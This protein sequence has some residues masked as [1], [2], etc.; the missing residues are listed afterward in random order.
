M[1]RTLPVGWVRIVSTDPPIT[2][3]ARL[4]PD[5]PDVTAG[6]GGWT[7]VTRPRRRPL[8]I[9]AGSPGLRMTLSILLDQWKA[10][11][12]VERQIAQLERL[13]TPTAAD[14]QPPRIRITSR[15][16]GVPHQRT[17]WVIDTITWGDAL[18]NRRGDRARQQATLS[19]LEFIA[20]ARIAEA[21]PANTR[22]KQTARGK[23]KAGAASKRVVAARKKTGSGHSRAAP[24]DPDFGAGD[25][26]LS[27]AA[28]ELGD[29]DRWI[30]IAQ[31][32]G[33][34]DPRAIR[35]GQVIRLP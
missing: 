22:R 10:G 28:R 18:A 19:L 33:L 26:L 35:P 3:T 9:W 30:E 29:A 17:A 23:S 4:G 27:I 11:T 12:S 21:S 15:G 25:D 24:A 2:V 5:R 14:G 7:E 20:D 34:R 1:T 8:S 31:L 6:Y 16:G 13:A 32:N